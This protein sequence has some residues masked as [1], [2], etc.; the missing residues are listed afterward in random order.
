MAETRF[1]W[2]ADE[3]QVLNAIQNIINQAE[4]GEQANQ[5]FGQSAQAAFE[6]PVKPLKD[7]ENQLKKS[8]SQM[9]SYEDVM[10]AIKART[11]DLTKENLRLKTELL[12]LEKAYS[13]SGKKGSDEAR[14]IKA[15]MQKLRETIKANNL[16]LAKLK[17]DEVKVKQFSRDM[18]DAGGAIKLTRQEATNLS[19][20]LNDVFVQLA[21]GQGIIRTLVQQGPQITQIFGGVG[22]TFRFL[23]QSALGAVRSIFTLRSAF[24]LL[25]GIPIVAILTAIVAALARSEKASRAVG[26]AF[27]FLGGAFDRFTKG[28]AEVGNAIIGFVTGQKSLNQAWNEGKTAV[29]GLGSEMAEAGNK[30]ARLKRELQDLQIATKQA[31]LFAI[32]YQSRLAEL[33]AIASDSSRSLAQREQALRTGTNIRLDLAQKELTLAR[34][35]LKTTEEQNRTAQGAIKTTESVIEARQRLADAETTLGEIQRRLSDGLRQLNEE[36][37][38]EAERR[39]KDLEQA[40]KR[41]QEI[42]DIVAEAN[43]RLGGQAQVL[44]IN[45][46]FAIRKIQELQREAE[47]LGLNLD[48]SSLFTIADA[49]LRRG[50]DKVNLALQDISQESGL[51]QSLSGVRDFTEELGSAI[52]EFKDRFNEAYREVL[53]GG[54]RFTDQQRQFIEQGIVQTFGEVANLIVTS[55][56]IQIAQQDAVIDRIRETTKVLEAQLKEQQQL[57]EKGY[58]NDVAALEKR[59]QE[60]NAKLA[61][62]QAERL[63]LQRKAAN[64]QLIADSLIQASQI[65]VAVATLLAEGAKGFVPGLL[66]AAA[67]VPLIFSIIARAKA[68]AAELA[69]PPT[70]RQGT[71]YLEGNSHEH[72]GVKIEAEGGERIISRKLNDMIGGRK[73]SNEELIEAYQIGANL[74]KKANLIAA[75]INQELKG[76]HALN[77]QREQIKIIRDSLE[78]TEMKKAYKEAA[79]QAASEIKNTIIDQIGALP[80]KYID[81]DGKEVIERT[82][83]GVKKIDRIE[84]TKD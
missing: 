72:G 80:K 7:L 68:N 84:R 26:Q 38:R 54:Q 65:G 50:L 2:T 63:E 11:N 59:L 49:D 43:A 30:A 1:T 8:V 20:Q 69:A 27:A 83:G 64:Q 57:K 70:F 29:S 6:S 55:T 60:E 48:F 34:Q 76:S 79:M 21:S 35:N 62:A 31:S 9:S 23:G 47:K 58:S 3:S 39:R 53:E 37:T 51:V 32:E 13:S 77:Q 19:F 75:P 25:I 18:R 17:F 12:S 10:Q 4:K 74:R 46:E 22:N 52:D 36:R 40:A 56:N 44:A 33:D 81:G 24:V 73:V 67:A 82:V 41:A 16:E 42:A 5:A 66:I 15:E 28:A 71:P 14:K 45:Y 61:K 78:L